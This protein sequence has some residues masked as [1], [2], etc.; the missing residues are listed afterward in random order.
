MPGVEG[1][2]CPDDHGD[3]ACS[4]LKH[5]HGLDTT[6]VDHSSVDARRPPGLKEGEELTRPGGSWGGQPNAEYL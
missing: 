2:S 3:S 4:S 6:P 5:R 1:F